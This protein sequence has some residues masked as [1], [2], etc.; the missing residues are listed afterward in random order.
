MHADTHAI[1]DIDNGRLPEWV[2]RD[3]PEIAKFYW[4]M[5]KVCAVCC[6]AFHCAL[7]IDFSDL[8][9]YF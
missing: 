7:K 3:V 4:K 2:N 8:S 5:P 9:L 6:L 1:S